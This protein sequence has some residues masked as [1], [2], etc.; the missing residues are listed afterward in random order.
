MRLIQNQF[1]V[2]TWSYV[3]NKFCGHRRWWRPVSHVLGWRCISGMF[4]CCGVSRMFCR[5]G[6]ERW[7]LGLGCG[8]ISRRLCCCWEDCTF[9]WRY[10]RRRCSNGNTCNIVTSSLSIANLNYLMPTLITFCDDRVP[11]YPLSERYNLHYTMHSM[12]NGFLCVKTMLTGTEI[13]CGDAVPYIRGSWPIQS[14]EWYGPAISGTIC[15][16]RWPAWPTGFA[17]CSHQ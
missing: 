13:T 16:C 15:P 12:R 14:H 9:F 1:T 3:A 5:S 11:T 8:G 17:L 7:S 10:G 6:W 4:R 2:R